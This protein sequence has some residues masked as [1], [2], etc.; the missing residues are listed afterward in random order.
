MLSQN[1]LSPSSGPDLC[2]LVSCW[3]SCLRSCLLG[4]LTPLWPPSQGQPAARARGSQAPLPVPGKAQRPSAEPG[5]PL[6]HLA[7]RCWSLGASTAFRGHRPPPWRLWPVALSPRGGTCLCVRPWPRHPEDRQNMWV[8]LP[9][10][11]RRGAGRSPSGSQEPFLVLI[12]LFIPSLS[13]H[14]AAPRTPCCPPWTG[15]R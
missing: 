15:T 13:P 5:V 8:L 1:L 4:P 7:S 12:R 14:R 10:P 11:V 9:H 2:T 3:P 6:H